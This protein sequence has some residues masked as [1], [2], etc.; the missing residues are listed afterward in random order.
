M[1][2]ERTLVY[3]LQENSM[4]EKRKRMLF[5][6]HFYAFLHHWGSWNC[7]WECMNW[8]GS[9]AA[10]HVVFLRSTTE[11]MVEISASVHVTVIISFTF[12][13]NTD[14]LMCFPFCWSLLR[15]VFAELNFSAFFFFFIISL[16]FQKIPI[17]I[18]R[19]SNSVFQSS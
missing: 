19:N 18:C 3:H 5:A 14:S 13:D 1:L 12:P 8:K 17:I 16:R 7:Y 4:K 6:C 10:V 2:W 9:D 11:V 15:N